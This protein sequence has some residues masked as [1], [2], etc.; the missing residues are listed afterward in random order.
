M[1]INGSGQFDFVGIKI[2]D[3]N[4]NAIPNS[5]VASPRSLDRANLIIKEQS[6]EKGE[7]LIIPI[8]LEKSIVGATAFQMRL[9][10]DASQFRIINVLDWNG[11]ALNPEE[12]II[13]NG[14]ITISHI[15]SSPTHDLFGI[16]VIALNSISEFSKAV[17]LLDFNNEAYSEDFNSIKIDGIKFEKEIQNIVVNVAPNPFNERTTLVIKSEINQNGSLSVYDINGIEVYR[18]PNISLTRGDN[19]ITLL[20]SQLSRYTGIYIYNLNFGNQNVRGKMIYLD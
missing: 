17:T 18:N 9:N 8:G 20:S 1:D 12:Y 10:I 19:E 15:D 2:G 7:R 5:L 3:V 6:A 16:E 11:N 13:E 14:V 4:T